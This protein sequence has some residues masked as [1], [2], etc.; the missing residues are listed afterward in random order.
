MRY[1]SYAELLKTLQPDVI[2]DF[3]EMGS[4]FYLDKAALCLMGLNWLI[5][6]SDRHCEDEFEDCEM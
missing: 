1:M 3:D 2:E 4:D 6:K 5:H